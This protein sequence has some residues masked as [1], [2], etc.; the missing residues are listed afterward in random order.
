MPLVTSPVAIFLTVLLIILLAPLLLNKLKIPHIIGLIAGGVIVGPHGLNLL[1]RDAGFEVFGQVGILYLMFLAGIEIDMYHLKKNLAKGLMF[2]AMTFLIPLVAGAFAVSL[3][4]KLDTLTA[5]LMASM[6]AAHTLI[7][8]PIISRFGLTKTP[9][10]IIAV[11]GTILTVLGSLIVLAGVI[12][13]FDHGSFSWLMTLRLIGYL[14]IFCVAISIIYPKLTRYFFKHYH[15]DVTRFIYVLSMMFIAAQGALMSGIEAV[16]GAFF[17]GLTLNRYIPTRS[18]L[19]GKIEFAGNAIFIPYFLIGVGMLINMESIAAGGYTLYI[20]GVMCAVAMVT[21]WLAAYAAQRAFKLKPLD[22]SVMYQLSNAH[23]AVALAVVM[24]G[25]KTGLFGEEILNA[26]VIMILVTCTVSSLGTGRA[27]RR[28]VLRKATENP[29]ETDKQNHD[30]THTLIS[31][32]SPENA[33]ALVD[34]AVLMRNEGPSSGKLYALHVRNDNS[35]SSRAIGRNSLDVAENA[36]A[37]TD[38]RVIPIER[39]DYNFVTGVLNTMAERDIANLFI[40]LHSRQGI[41]DSFFGSKIEQLLH[42]TNRMVVISRCFIPVNTV[43]RIV[44]SV[45]DKAE[46]ETGFVRWLCAVGNLTRQI[47]CRVIFCASEATGHAIRSVL[48]H[49]RY[50]ISYEFRQ[51][52]RWDDFIMLADKIL[53]D[54]LFIIVGSRRQSVSFEADMDEL[55]EFLQKYFGGNNLMVLYPEQFGAEPVIPT[56]AETMTTDMRSTPSPLWTLIRRAVKALTPRQSS[57]P[58]IDL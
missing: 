11:A 18:S 50:G 1:A 43:T 3:L 33:K 36:G 47:G 32:G 44:V 23:T 16:F 49:N 52:G 27:A 56:M 55:P 57:T 46:F 30:S 22:R 12:D 2:G 42:T 9:A 4:L 54:D 26:T 40:G 8:Y 25:L 51:A 24:I 34:L 13:I 28:L 41:I 14:I 45:P 20:A 17:A 19:M 7:G 35:P 38:T 53:P 58:R 48:I 10:V 21:K 31:V 6:F 5:V 39:Y 37:A 15:D 29:V